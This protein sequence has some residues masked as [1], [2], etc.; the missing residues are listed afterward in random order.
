M[1]GAEG[2]EE[3][4]FAC[5]HHGPGTYKFSISAYSIHLRQPSEGDEVGRITLISR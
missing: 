5:I 2:G 4:T 3:I 1:S